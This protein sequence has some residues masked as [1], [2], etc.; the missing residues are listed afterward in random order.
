M[1]EEF[2]AVIKLISGEE[3]FSKV[4]SCD[5]DERTI[6]ILDNPVVVQVMNIQQMGLK[7]VRMNPWVTFTSDTMFVMDLDKVITMSEVTDEDFIRMY[8]K[9]TKGKSKK[10][11]KAKL[12]KKMGYV[13]SIAEARE[14][15][16]RLYNKTD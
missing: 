13:S 2:Y 12:S 10:T 14:T 1:E 11:N 6:L 5:E 15:L 3:I 4:C 7:A 8:N 16:E 9:F